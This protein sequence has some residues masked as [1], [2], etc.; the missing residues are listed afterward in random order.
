MYPAAI[1]DMANGL[2]TESALA[3]LL[4]SANEPARAAPTARATGFTTFFSDIF[5]LLRGCLP[6]LG[7]FS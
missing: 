1:V 5:S 4:D 7:S 6:K 3:M 2:S